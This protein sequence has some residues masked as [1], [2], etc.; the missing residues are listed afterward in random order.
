[1]A[2]G[3]FHR[4]VGSWFTRTLG[5]P[6][7]PQ[8][9]AWP[10]IQARQDVLIAAP[11]GSGKTLAAFL[12]I[13]DELYEEG[14]ERPLP[15]A[16]RVLYVSPLRALSNDIHQNLEAP[17]AGIRAE[18]RALGLPDVEL[19]T[20]VR[21]GD[22]SPKERAAIGKVPPHVLVTT[23]ESLY[24]LLGSESG[25]RTLSTVDTVIVDE[26]HALVGNKRGSHLALSL[27]R[28]QALCKKP[29][30]R[31]GLSAT[32][33]PLSEVAKFL[34]GSD[35]LLADGTPA[36]TIVDEGHRRALDLALEL[37]RSPLEAV[38]SAEVWDE[39]HE[40]LC[41][42]IA[43]H[44]TT[45]VF[46]NTRRMAER[47][48]AALTER[49]GE[50]KVTS[51]HGSLAAPLRLHAEERL[52]RG[53]LSALV[54][55]A[56]LELG[57]DI[58]A[59]DLVCQIGSTRA[60][61][62]FLQRVGRSGHHK[63]LTPK[64]R[65]FPLSRDELSECA[66]LVRAVR[67]GDLDAV[68]IPTAPLD[69]LAQQLVA[70]SAFDD[71]A[72]DELYALVRRAYPYR[73]L[74]R[75]RFDE[76]VRMLAD[77]F[78]TRR[79]RRGAHLHHDPVNERIRGKKGARLAA[80]MSGGAIPDNADYAVVLEPTGAIIGTLNEDFA[81]ES[82]PGDIFLLGNNSWQITRVENGR[83]RV[84]DAAGQPPT[85]PFWLG[86]A[87]GRTRE[88]S[89]AVSRL[90]QELDA[91]LPDVPAAVTLL[92]QKVGV[93][94]A[95]A[96]QLATYHAAIKHV[97]GV[98][99]TASTIVAERFF[100]ESGGM[101][102][103]LH[104][105]LG[106]RINRAFGL[107][108]RKCFCRTFNFE[109][110]AAATED[111]IVLSLGAQHSFPLEDVFR[112][113]S[114]QSV[115]DILVQALLAAPMF[116]TRWRWNASRSLALLRR[117]GGKPTP[118]AILRMEA[119]DLVAAVFPEQLACAE[120]IVGDR[121]VPDHP[122][123]NQTI[124]D[125]LH[126]AMDLPGLVAVLEGIRGGSIRT[127]ARDLPEPSP[128]AHEILSARPYAFL[129]D[130]PLEERRTRAVYTRRV[131]EPEAARELGALDAG[132]IERVRHDVFPRATS[133]DEA[134]DAL[135]QLGVATPAEVE[136]FAEH[137][138]PLAAEGRATRAT[139][140][141]GQ[142]VWVAAERLPE[143]QLL[144][145]QAMLQPALQLPERLLA[146]APKDADLALRELV[147]GRL[148]VS[149]PLTA[150]KLAGL[151]GVDESSAMGALLALEAEGFVL[152]GA[153]TREAEGLEWCER[154]VLARIHR[155]TVNRLR[156]E[157]EPVPV[158]DFLRFLTAW[159]RLAPGY[160]ARGPE[161]LRAVLEQL[162]GFHCPAGAWESEVLPARVEDYEPAWL[163][164]L[165]L[166]GQVGWGRLAETGGDESPGRSSR[167][168]V[169]QSPVA[170]FLRDH[171]GV[172]AH[173]RAEKSA[174]P[175]ATRLLAALDRRGASFASELG[176]ASGLLPAQLDAALGELVALGA[177]T[178]DAFTGLRGLLTPERG[179]RGR[180]AR[181]RPPRQASLAY[182]GRWSRL[183]PEPLEPEADPAAVL[184]AKARV[185]LR[186]YGVLCR[187]VLLRE[188]DAPPWRDL[189]RTLRRLEARGELRGGH[190]VA[191][192]GGEHFALPEA[193][194]LLRSLRREPGPGALVTLSAADP[195]NLT[196]ILGPGARV[197]AQLKNRVLLRDGVP[198][199]ALEAG[200]L[201]VLVEGV[202]SQAAIEAA[203]SGAKARVRPSGH[204][205][206]LRRLTRPPLASR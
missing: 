140:R 122:L 113:L 37:P 78:S 109:L 34:V 7:A 185:L 143:L 88:L 168:A 9:R 57:I 132:A 176:K 112:F 59:V 182:A 127:V 74:T 11:T 202:V 66:A 115:R 26:I 197:P 55:T 77:G 60:I 4:A 173:G 16:T 96:E 92:R 120:N 177:I 6:T 48:T 82:M 186:R 51:H 62:T 174:G 80:L 91:A 117:R 178:S 8:E 190:F 32:Q 103:V 89:A 86:E 69:I 200:R 183:R 64:G 164:Q 1:M 49:L 108:L 204:E 25:R 180:H 114:P 167:G 54:A 105:P 87:P 104:A 142:V 94:E 58:G 160:R 151:F 65:L 169:R 90:R 191:G 133:P 95:A 98:L 83:V 172:H 20:A 107:A 63:L 106:S 195:L 171:L 158:S 93:D 29:L 99:P 139:L 170:L 41:E 129:D 43:Q 194:G 111:A 76:V 38:M 84:A 163:D 135:A 36:C 124:D 45:L 161:G 128:L 28:L 206:R 205:P 110:Q 42:L 130:A 18:L 192:L 136:P 72:A 14:L 67:E 40:R 44:K 2:L 23:P 85:I 50:G 47:L 157:I 33:R 156:A 144:H 137:L 3:T 100:D 175:E 27:A 24:L 13:L 17:L 126:E 81:I 53:E 198:V 166:S 193:V 162:D 199:A 70:A 119:E 71:F 79:G 152:R 30:R 188:R 75:Q 203:L 97:L 116:Q 146:R 196:G 149:G 123:V 141:H 147:R 101:Q 125:C 159:Q 46:V 187:A 181:L 61:A 52:K 118:P 153:F 145:P 189:A 5:E 134:Y 21:T 15:D 150:A 35:R 73:D 19:R 154:R 179:T 10:A 155:L 56:S 165:C 12:A 22:T 39:V 184:E 68:E 102:L 148:E 201:S 31:I 121:E 131:L 138:A